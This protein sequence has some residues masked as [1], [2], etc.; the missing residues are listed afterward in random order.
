MCHVTMT[1]AEVWRMRGTYSMHPVSKFILTPYYTDGHC[2][3][4]PSTS[5]DRVDMHTVATQH[6]P[7]IIVSLLTYLLPGPCT[8]NAGYDGQLTRQNAQRT[9]QFRTA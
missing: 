1:G 2:L 7:Y 8:L 6:T 3:P 4:H 5:V 9:N